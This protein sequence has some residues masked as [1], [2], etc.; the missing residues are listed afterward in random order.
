MH[1]ATLRRSHVR[2]VGCVSPGTLRVEF[3]PPPADANFVRLSDILTSDVPMG[4]VPFG[5]RRPNAEFLMV[6]ADQ[7]QVVAVEPLP[8]T[9]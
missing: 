8:P 4:L 1:P 5:L 3:V 9:A 7:V 6:L 2:V